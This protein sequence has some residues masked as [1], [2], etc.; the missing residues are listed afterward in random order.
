ML[1]SVATSFRSDIPKNHS[2]NSEDLSISNTHHLGFMTEYENVMF[3]L[4]WNDLLWIL[5]G[6][7][8]DWDKRPVVCGE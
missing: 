2:S 3:W 4:I 5:P 6:T 7:P 8:I 1:G